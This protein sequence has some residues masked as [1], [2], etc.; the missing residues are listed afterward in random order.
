MPTYLKRYEAR[1]TTAC[2]SR[3]SSTSGQLQ[4]YGP[5]ARTASWAT[6]HAAAREEQGAGK[7]QPR[8]MSCSDQFTIDELNDLNNYLAWNIWDVLVMRATEGVSGMIPARNTR[9]S[10][11]CR[12]SIASR[13]SCG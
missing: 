5:G 3:T 4:G 10:R 1:A 12:S 2:G 8:K 11:S 13:N 9:F 7:G 6:G